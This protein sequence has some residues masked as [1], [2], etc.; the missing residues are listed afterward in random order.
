VS[1]PVV[2]SGRLIITIC[3]CISLFFPSREVVGDEVP[4][5]ADSEVKET[6]VEL[7]Q[8]HPPTELL[9]KLGD[10]WKKQPSSG[11]KCSE[12]E[13]EE[14]TKLIIN[15]FN[16]PSNASD[17]D[18]RN[19]CGFLPRE[20]PPADVCNSLRE[21]AR[22]HGRSCYDEINKKVAKAIDRAS[23]RVQTIRMTDKN[24]KTGATSCEA[25]LYATLENIGE[26]SVPI[27]Y[28]I[29]KTLDTDGFYVK[30]YYL[31]K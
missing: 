26:S 19:A 22:E 9:K 25:D 23:Y 12:R 29:T 15:R 21:Q 24:E 6:V 30:M 8:E 31:G 13:H 16:L 5:C 11:P 1:V 20:H 10:E 7:V 2:P 28:E 17:E 4:G 27:E 3:F 18:I 14:G